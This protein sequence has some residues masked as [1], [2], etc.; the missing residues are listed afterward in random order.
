MTSAYAEW[1]QRQDRIVIPFNTRVNLDDLFGNVHSNVVCER[2]TPCKLA[3]YVLVQSLDELHQDVQPFTP[4]EHCS[5]LSALYGM[6]EHGDMSFLEVKRVVRWM[7]RTVRKGIYK[8]FVELSEIYLPTTQ[9]VVVPFEIESSGRARKW[10]ANQMH[11]LQVRLFC[12]F[13]CPSAALPDNEIMDWCQIIRKN[14]VDVVEVVNM[15]LYILLEK[16]L[17]YLQ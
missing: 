3:I 9:P 17:Q 6:I 7:D 11:L 14:H 16:I 4:S 5:L 10:I 8:D 13:V 1:N 12:F 2:I 15:W